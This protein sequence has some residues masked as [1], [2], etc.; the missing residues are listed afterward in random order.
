MKIECGNPQV[1][2]PVT[3]NTSEA[4][5]YVSQSLKIL[6]VKER[7]VTVVWKTGHL[8]KNKSEI[9]YVST[10]SNEAIRFAVATGL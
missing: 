9:I 10:D 2:F 5:L 8:E 3:I 6:V 1:T 4:M 7:F